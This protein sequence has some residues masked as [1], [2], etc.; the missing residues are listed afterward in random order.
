MREVALEKLTVYHAQSAPTALK[1]VRNLSLA[2]L[3]TSVS[4]AHRRRL[5]VLVAIIATRIMTSLHVRVQSITIVNEAHQH[6]SSVG[7]KISIFVYTERRCLFIADPAPRLETI[8]ASKHPTLVSS[9]SRVSTQIT[10]L[11]VASLAQQALSAMVE[12]IQLSQLTWQTI[13]VLSVPRATTALK[14]LGS[15]ESVLL[16]HTTRLRAERLGRTASCVHLA[17]SK[18]NGASLA[19]ECADNS[20]TL[21]RVWTSAS[22]LASTVLTRLKTLLADARVAMITLMKM[23]NLKATSVTLLIASL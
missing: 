1:A 14:E 6:Q 22:A 23:S 16:A 20:L 7:S 2:A 12:P 9:A 21:S 17:L 5:P 19:A 4:Q 8:A 10:S 13:K 18:T 11:M 3:V 15:P